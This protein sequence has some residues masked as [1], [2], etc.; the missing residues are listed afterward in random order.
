M[1]RSGKNIYKT[2]RKRAEI[3]AEYAAEQ[4]NINVRTLY[5]YECGELIPPYDIIVKMCELYKT[6]YLHIKHKLTTDENWRDI[7]PEISEQNIALS[8][9]AFLDEL[10]KVEK[11]K[12]ELI[13]ISRDGVISED[14]R[15]TWET[16]DKYLQR[17]IKAVYE[18]K[19]SEKENEVYA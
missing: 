15:P 12:T 3:T 19:Y 13:E 10:N 9:L 11:W 2:A 1:P 17:L 4:L 6:P 5:K 16:I 18:L 8:T 7:V 14:E